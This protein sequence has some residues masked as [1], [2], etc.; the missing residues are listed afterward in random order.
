MRLHVP[1]T[2]HWH[3]TRTI[4]YFSLI[5]SPLP[6]HPPPPKKKT[7][8]RVVTCGYTRYPPHI[9]RKSIGRRVCELLI[10]RRHDPDGKGELCHFFVGI[11]VM[12][13]RKLELA[14]SSS[15]RIA[16]NVRGVLWRL[17]H[18]VGVYMNYLLV[19]HA[20]VHI[21]TYICDRLVVNAESY[22]KAASYNVV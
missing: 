14:D 2:A 18:L 3:P 1:T 16:P 5:I 15:D 8:I 20:H 13:P 22:N 17:K 12:P 4:R 10:T 11:R 19:T 7:R 9:R 21:H 6:S